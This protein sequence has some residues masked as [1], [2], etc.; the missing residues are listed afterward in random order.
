MLEA[1][2]TFLHVRVWSAPFALGNYAVL[3]WVLEPWAGA[4]VE[5]ALQTL[6]NGANI[7]L[8]S[9]FV[10]GFGWSLGGRRSRTLIA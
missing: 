8:A 5:L 4:S 9:L 10:L 3:G 2:R 7:V 1:A 6:L